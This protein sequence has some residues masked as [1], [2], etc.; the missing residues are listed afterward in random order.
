M[1]RP[2]K[3]SVIGRLLEKETNK[4]LFF[5][6]DLNEEHFLLSTGPQWVKTL[7]IYE[8][9]LNNKQHLVQQRLHVF[10]SNIR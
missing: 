4:V 9:S 1:T 3:S 7:T 2:N 6:G 8:R 5:G 10:L